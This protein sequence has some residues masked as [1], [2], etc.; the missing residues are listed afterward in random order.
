M[1]FKKFSHEQLCNF[2]WDIWSPGRYTGNI[3]INIRF[4]KIKQ[5]AWF[6]YEFKLTNFPIY[7]IYNKPDA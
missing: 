1:C 7:L 5:E 2:S 3:F 4:K 6:A